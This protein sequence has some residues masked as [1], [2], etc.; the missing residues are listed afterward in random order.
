MVLS[1]KNGGVRKIRFLAKPSGKMTPMG[2][3][4]HETFK[5]EGFRLEDDRKPKTIGDLFKQR[6]KAPVILD[7]PEEYKE[8]RIELPEKKE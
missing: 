4:D 8:L 1:F 3:I 6:A 5:L 2:D 7:L